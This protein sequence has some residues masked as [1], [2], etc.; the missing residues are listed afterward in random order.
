MVDREE[1]REN[2]IGTAI[3]GAALVVHSAVGPG[4]LESAYQVCLA[5]ELAK[6]NIRVRAQFCVPIRY[7]NVSIDNGYRLDLLVE[8]RMAVE[9]K[10]V[11]VIRPVHRAQL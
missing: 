9:L 10:A 6:R 4:L 3:V 5:H 8:E 11:E 1:F 7:D 2:Q